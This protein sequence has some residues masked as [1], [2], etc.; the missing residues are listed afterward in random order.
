MCPVVILMVSEILRTHEWKQTHA[1]TCMKTNLCLFAFTAINKFVLKIAAH[2]QA[3][4]SPWDEASSVEEQ[5]RAQGPQQEQDTVCSTPGTVAQIPLTAGQSNSRR[6][7]HLW[8][9]SRADI[10]G[11]TALHGNVFSSY[12]N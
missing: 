3:E 12:T 1:N 5:N 6:L 9:R 2:L 7:Q 8:K 4:E 10:S 11:G